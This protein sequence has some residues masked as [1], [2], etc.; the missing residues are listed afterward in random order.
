MIRHRDCTERGAFTLVEVLV[1]IGVIGL[2]VALLIPAVQ[3]ARES[4]RRLKCSNNLHQ[5]GIALQAY[6]SSFGMLPGAYSGKAFSIHAMLLPG[7]EQTT[8]Y[9]SINFSCASVSLSSRERYPNLTSAR[10]SVD[11]FLCPSD[12]ARSTANGPGRITREASASIAETVWIMGRSTSIADSVGP[13][14]FH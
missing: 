12:C 11:L 3:S 4:A 6:A 9:N 2:L 1:A 5:L 14:G 8:L 7:L 10:T 13:P